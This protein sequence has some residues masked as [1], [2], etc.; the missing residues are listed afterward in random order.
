MVTKGANEEA[1]PEWGILLRRLWVVA[2]EFT[3]SAKLGYPP[4]GDDDLELH[5]GTLSLFPDDFARR[6]PTFPSKKAEDS[7]DQLCWWKPKG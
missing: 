1:G 7:G 4:E 3:T 2:K 5:Q 6:G